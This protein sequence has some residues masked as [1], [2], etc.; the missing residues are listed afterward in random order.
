MKEKSCGAIIFKVQKDSSTKYLLLH[1]EA[2]HWDFPKG[3][4]EK[5]ETEK[6]TALR[7]INEE[8]GIKKIK[9][10]AGFKENINYFYK[11][12]ENIVYKDVVFYLLQSTTEKVKLSKEHIGYSWLS[13]DNAYKKITYK[14]SKELLR[15]ADEFITKI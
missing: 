15:K 7:E 8:T 1:Y 3:H 4:Q 6:Q 11:K 12:G 14:N 5:N 13:Y 10:I 2:G 9:F